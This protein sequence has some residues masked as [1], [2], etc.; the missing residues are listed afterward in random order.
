MLHGFMTFFGL[1]NSIESRCKALSILRYLIIVKPFSAFITYVFIFILSANKVL[2][3][4]PPKPI[5]EMS[6]A[7]VPAAIKNVERK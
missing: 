6:E 7:T 5:E 4:L 1:F 3:G 2:L